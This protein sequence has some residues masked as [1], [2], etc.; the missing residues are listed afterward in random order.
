MASFSFLDLQKSLLV[1]FQGCWTQ[2]QRFESSSIHHFWDTPTAFSQNTFLLTKWL[3]F[4]PRSPEI[5]TS[6]F[7]GVLNTMVTVLKVSV[8]ISGFSEEINEKM[9]IQFCEAQPICAIS[10]KICTPKLQLLHNT[11]QRSLDM[12][13]WLMIDPP[14]ELT[15]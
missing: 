6:K 13:R 14:G 10:L 5:P 15:T 3:S 9:F 2:W 11:E 1:S 4:I 7:P 12:E 8:P